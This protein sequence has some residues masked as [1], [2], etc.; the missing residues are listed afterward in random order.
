[1][2]LPIISTPIYEVNLFSQ[3]EPVKF[4]PFLVKEQKLLLMAT[5][6]DDVN[7]VIKIVKQIV[8]N[9]ILDETINVDEL[10]LVDIEKL[11]LNFRARSM[12][13]NIDVFFKCKNMV[14]N[15]GE[16]KK[17]CGM[18]I[19]GSINLLEVPIVN[20]DFISKIMLT[21]DVGVKMRLPTFEMIQ[22]LSN[23]Q[24]NSEESENEEFIS[25]ASCIDFIFDK[26]TVYYSKDATEEEMI[27]FLL[28]LEPEKYDLILNFFKTLPTIRQKLDK[29]CSKCGFEHKFVLEG[30]ND[31]FI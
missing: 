19:E 13:E 1:M 26:E 31:F 3:K 16:E 23:I 27:N 21:D 28:S 10:P 18:V 17:E 5:E 7:E 25:V 29:T 24:N 8:K 6:Q 22:K 12:G 2:K 20:E 30:L 4:R 15:D 9:C 14:G 11:F